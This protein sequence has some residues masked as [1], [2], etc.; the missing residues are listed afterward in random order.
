MTDSLLS[1]LMKKPIILFVILQV[2]QTEKTQ[3]IVVFLREKKFAG[4]IRPTVYV[5]SLSFRKSEID[6]IVIRNDRNTPYYLTE[7]YATALDCALLS[8]YILWAGSNWTVEGVL[9]LPHKQ[10]EFLYVKKAITIGIF[11][12][13][14]SLKVHSNI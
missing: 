12:I 5:Q 7:Q 9:H 13:S 8:Y 2:T 10:T 6:V 4:G 11:H 14:I 1:V 3:D